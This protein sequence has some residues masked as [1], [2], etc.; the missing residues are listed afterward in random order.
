MKRYCLW[1]AM[2]LLGV[3]VLSASAQ[4]EQGMNPFLGLMTKAGAHAKAHGVKVAPV[5]SPYDGTLLGENP[6]VNVAELHKAGFRVIPWTTDTPEK[7]KALIA[8]R[9]DGI[10]SDYPDM[11]QAVLKEEKAA[12]PDEAAYF[13][14]FDVSAHR[15]GRG[16]RPENTL[17]SFEDGLDHLST[18]LETDTGV[19]TDH[20]SLIW[21]DQFLNPQSCRKADGSAYTLENKVYTRDISSVEAQK[22]FICDKLHFGAQQTNDLALSP[23]AVEFAKQEHLI[24]PYVPT[25]VEQLF[26]F[27]RFYAH[28]YKDGVGKG[29]PGA[30]ARWRNAE[31]VRFNLETKILPELSPAE[32][33]AAGEPDGNHTVGP[34]LFVKTLCGAIKR[35]H[36]EGRS[37][38]QSFDFRTLILVEE[39]YPEIPTYYLTGPAKTLSSELVPVSLRQAAAAN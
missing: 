1:L 5:L 31:T 10:I 15:G 27:V 19:T 39:Q 7:M 38:V 36:M 23:V 24:S 6:A 3:G 35:N 14:S 2:G 33:K 25:Y 20:V 34:E 28:Y 26:R 22:M 4:Q 29:T 32:A 37:E 21:H 17:P 11:L 30:E 12:H 16:L 8:L 9:V 13:A 18:T